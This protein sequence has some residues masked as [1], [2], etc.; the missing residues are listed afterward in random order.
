MVALHQVP[1][2]KAFHGLLLVA[3]DWRDVSLTPEGSNVRE[4]EP[5]VLAYMSSMRLIMSRRDWSEEKALGS[6]CSM[7]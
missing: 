4:N 5:K 3:L 6:I 1:A 2:S 7:T